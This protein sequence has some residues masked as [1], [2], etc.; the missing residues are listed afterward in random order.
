MSA[1]AERIALV[2]MTP[3]TD[4]NETG[5]MEMPSYGVKRILAAAAG[6][7]WWHMPAHATPP[8]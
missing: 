5:N 8:R 2:C 1:R 7:F 4:A 6:D 3:I